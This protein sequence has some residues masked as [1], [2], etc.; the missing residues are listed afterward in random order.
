M[1][2]IGVLPIDMDRDC[3]FS[4]QFS[5]TMGE[6]LKDSYGGFCCRH[7]EAVSYYKEQL[8]NNKKFQSLIRVRAAS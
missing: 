8:Q 4:M 2:G 1:D 7:T 6:R 5:G 3:R